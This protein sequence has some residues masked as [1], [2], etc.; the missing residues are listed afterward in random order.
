VIQYPII[1]I[2]GAKKADFQ[3]RF[4]VPINHFCTTVRLAKLP[5]GLPTPVEHVDATIGPERIIC[6]DAFTPF[7]EALFVTSDLVPTAKIFLQI[8]TLTGLWNGTVSDGVSRNKGRT[9]RQANGSQSE[10]TQD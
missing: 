6:G 3:F 1:A 10:A 5:V 8:D 4:G 2:E 9:R 7:L